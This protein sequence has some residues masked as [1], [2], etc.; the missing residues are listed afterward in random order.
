MIQIV[1]FAS[2][3]GTNAENIIKYFSNSQEILVT[4][5]LCN[6][7]IAKVFERCERLNVPCSLFE[8]EDFLKNDTVLHFLQQEQTDFIILAGFLWKIPKNLLKAFPNKIINIHPALLPKYGGKGMYGMHVH[9]AVKANNELE[10]G[11]TIHFINENYDE[12]AIIF[13]VKT[14]LS[15]EDT[16]EMIAEK[17]HV[18]EQEHFPKVIENELLKNG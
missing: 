7:P 16:P 5:V 9:K 2:G 10:T 1:I 3:S 15:P 6:N 18:L 11:I 12:G 14:M 17:I 8:K 13:Q 4:N